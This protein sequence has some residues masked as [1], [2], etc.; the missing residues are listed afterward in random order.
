MGSVR[1]SF[2]VLRADSIEERPFGAT[3]VN[4]CTIEVEDEVAVNNT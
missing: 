4:I 2:H 1:P 3:E